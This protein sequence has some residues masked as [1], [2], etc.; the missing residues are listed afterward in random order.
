MFARPERLPMSWYEAG[1]DEFIRIFRNPRGRAALYASMRN[2]Y[3]DEPAGDQGFWRRLEAMDTPACFLWGD[4]DRL[5]PSGFSRHVERAL[6]EARS[7]VLSDCGHVPQFEHP[8]TTHGIVRG[9]IDA[10][11]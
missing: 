10:A 8:D 3:L 6:P 11:A 5:V 4:R 7:V 2:I 9:F 1:A